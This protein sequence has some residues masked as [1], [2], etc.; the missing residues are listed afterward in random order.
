MTLAPDI[1]AAFV[2]ALGPAHVMTGP[3]DMTPYLTEW[4]DRWEGRAAAVLRPADTAETA[5]AVKLAARH[6]L[7]LV[8]QGGNTGLVGGQIPDMS[9]GQIVLSLGRLNRIRRVDAAG[10]AMIAEAGVT[11]KAVQDAAAEAGLLFPLSLGAEG[12]ATIGGNLSTNAGG[13]AVLAYGAARDLA[14]GLEV[15]LPDGRV[16]NG[17]RTLRKDNTG[18][19]LKNLFIGAEGTLGVITAASLKL[20]ARPRGRAT[21]FAATPSPAAALEALRLVREAAPGVVTSFEL[22]P[23]IG[24]EFVLRHT[25]GARDPLADE[26][27][28]YALIE[29]SSQNAGDL[30]E[31]SEAALAEA[32]ERGALADAAIAR[33][34]AQAAAFWRLRE[35]M[36]AAQKPEGGSIKHDVSVPVAAA[37]AFIEEATR[38]ALAFAPGCRPVPFGHLGDGNIHFN[39]SQPP[40]ADREAYLAGWAGMNDAI[41]AVVAR[42]GGSISAEHG[43]GVAKRDLLPGVKS[44]IEMELMRTLKRALDPQGIM[45]PG[46]VL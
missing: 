25:P 38:A 44:D 46:K 4:R 43:I 45:N 19:D 29:I 36:S 33:S 22:M 13:V 34:E 17:L 18:Y 28:W 24:L 41:H 30:T 39:V 3:D 5:Q 40:G 32:L 6:G 15:V 27:P 9:G 20:F 23:R 26:S 10:F 37:P 2:E 1:R 16:W 21:I 35:S 12:T 7:A 14:L 42:F 11:L 31:A 8:P